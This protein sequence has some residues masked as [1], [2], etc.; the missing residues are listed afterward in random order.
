M[1][2]FA[3]FEVNGERLPAE[4]FL[5]WAKVSINSQSDGSAAFCSRVYG[6]P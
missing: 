4:F 5:D 3:D 2:R 6:C 1:A